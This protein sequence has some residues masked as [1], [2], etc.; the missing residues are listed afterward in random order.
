MKFLNFTAYLFSVGALVT[1]FN[2]YLVER[3]EASTESHLLKR[4]FDENSCEEVLDENGTM[5]SLL[6]L[7]NLQTYRTYLDLYQN[8]HFQNSYANLSVGNKLSITEKMF[9]FGWNEPVIKDNKLKVKRYADIIGIGS[10]KCGTGAFRRF[11]IE[12]PQIARYSN[13]EAHFFDSTRFEDKGLS[14]YMERMPFSSS[15]QVVYEETPRYVA[16]D[17]VPEKISESLPNSKEIKFV[18]IVCDPVGRAFSDYSHKVRWKHI[19]KYASFEDFVMKSIETLRDQAG[20]NGSSFRNSVRQ[21]YFSTQNQHKD[22][23]ILTNGLYHLHLV[24]NWVA[25]FC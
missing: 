12:H 9:S 7:I 17:G 2:N 5:T 21:M 11:L 6:N 1:I 23:T 14:Y 20:S 22:L 18:H 4:S 16:L 15:D 19:G 10:K 3:R 24:Y 25:F 13:N 8:E